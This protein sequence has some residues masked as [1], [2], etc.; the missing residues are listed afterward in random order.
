MNIVDI[1]KMN[2]YMHLMISE[3]IFYQFSLMLRLLVI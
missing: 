2:M 1:Q 3:M